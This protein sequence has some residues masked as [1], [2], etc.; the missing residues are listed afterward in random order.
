MEELDV[1]KPLEALARKMVKNI[2]NGPFENKVNYIE[3]LVKE[4]EPDAVINFCHWGCK[5]ANGGSMLLKESMSK[6]NVPILILDGDAMDRRNSHD[7]Q[8]KTRFEA[9]LELIN[10][11]D[12]K[13]C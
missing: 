7:G 2:F 12:E 8:I 4:L 3:K 11:E 1:D 9:F 10:K 13:F 5:Q 6:L